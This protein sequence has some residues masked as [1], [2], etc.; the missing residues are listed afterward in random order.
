DSYAIPSN[1]VKKVVDD[2]IEFGTVQRAF[3]GIG[4]KDAK[5]LSVD[6]IREL[7]IDKQDGVYVSKVMED[8]A[9]QKAG[10]KEGDFIT[11]V[12]GMQI[13]SSPELLEQIARFRPGDN[14]SVTYVRS[15]KPTHTTVELKNIEGNTKIIKTNA[16]AKMLG[17]NL[18]SLSKEEL[19]KYNV[20]GG[21]KVSDIEN[22]VISQQTSMKNGFIITKA[23]GV[24]IN[25]VQE[26]QNLFANNSG[27]IELAGFYPDRNGVFYYGINLD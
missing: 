16:P 2:I 5:M 12:N 8:G 27:K 13:N 24:N 15:G 6:E 4:Y 22:G 21:I 11:A 20:A 10:I 17:A 25:N 14:V 7:G 19:S 26:L 1:L 9:A 3:L 23:N 18:V